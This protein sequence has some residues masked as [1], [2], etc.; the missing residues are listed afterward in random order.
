MNP[1][2]PETE[3]RLQ[4]KYG[5]GSQKTAAEW[6]QIKEDQKKRFGKSFFDLQFSDDIP[7]RIWYCDQLITI[8]LN[9]ISAKKAIGKTIFGIQLASAIADGKA[10]LELK[11]IQAKVLYVSFELDESDIHHRF[12]KADSTMSANAFIVYDFPS[13]ENALEDCERLFSEYDFKVIFFDTFLPL[14]PGDFSTD[15][16]K[17]SGFYLRFRQ[18]AKRYNAAIVAVWHNCKTARDDFMLNLLGST[19]MGAQGDSILSL[20]R[21]RGDSI[22]TLSIGGNHAKDQAI[23]IIMTDSL[24]WKR[25]EGQANFNVFSDQEQRILDYMET[26]TDGVTPARISIF[27]SKTEGAARQALNRLVERGKVVKVKRGIFAINKN[28]EMEFPANAE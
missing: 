25:T 22:A 16:Y 13:G 9:F 6:A 4:K 14:L 23:K 20:D 18:L 11:T 7:E 5:S 19:G 8:G 10:F 3:A 2:T 15:S 1:L 24:S 17:D 28:I 12:R 26:Q 27:L 21:K